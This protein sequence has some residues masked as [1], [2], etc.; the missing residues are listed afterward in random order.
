MSIKLLISELA[1]RDRYVTREAYHVMRE[2]IDNYGWMHLETDELTSQPNS[3][4]ERIRER[5]GAL[6]DVVLFWESYHL[7]TSACLQLFNANFCVAIYCE[8]L[9]WFHEGMRATKMLALSV[10][11]IILASYAPVFER[12][13]PEVAALKRAVWVPHAASPEFMMPLNDSAQNVV[14]LS[15]KIDDYYPL[16][17][18]LKALAEKTELQVVELSHPGYECRHNHETSQAVGAGYA[19]RINASRAAFTDASKFKYVLA[20]FFEIP[21]TGSLL[22][23]DVA[24]EKELSQ[25]GFL[26]REHYV[27]VSDATLESELR[28]VLDERNHAELDEVRRRGQQ[29]IWDRHKISDRVRLIDSVCTRGEVEAA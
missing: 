11:N 26:P 21:A 4:R 15:G 1:I 14:F 24:V 8:D 12:F 3:L 25:L 18:R 20:K 22:V 16:R 7:V 28:Y 6:P 2:L 27:P 29:L 23:G 13:F 9:H 5:C 19:R 10:A 17:Q